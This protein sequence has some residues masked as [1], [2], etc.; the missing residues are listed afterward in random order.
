[1]KISKKA[2]YGL[3]AMV[4]LAKNKEVTSIRTLAKEETL[5]EEYLEKIIQQL[6]KSGL[7]ESTKGQSGGYK[8]ALSPKLISANHILQVLDGALVPFPC[9]SGV[10][11]DACSQE[12]SCA[13]SD[14]WKKLSLALEDTLDS[15][16]LA[17][18]IR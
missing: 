13:T 9:S 11:G 14:V 6:R 2:Y 12:S 15:I 5:P 10:Q 4:F 3:K 7:V 8:L 16:T 1:M 18:L 17:D